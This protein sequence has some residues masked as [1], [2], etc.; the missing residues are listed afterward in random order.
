[1]FVFQKTHL[2]NFTILSEAI[3]W[4]AVLPFARLEASKHLRD[5][6]IVHEKLRSILFLQNEFLNI[7]LIIILAMA[8]LFTVKIL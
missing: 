1:M 8:V 4:I 7:Y 6:K 5:W 3:F 2:G